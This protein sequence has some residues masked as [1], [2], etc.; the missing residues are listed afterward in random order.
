ML[1][2]KLSNR[3]SHRHRILAISGALFSLSIPAFAAESEATQAY[4][5]NG[6]LEYVGDLDE[7]ANQRLFDLY[8]KLSPKPTVLSIR[9]P[10]GEVNAGMTL[11]AWVHAHKL[12]VKVMEFCLSACANY[13]F[14]AGS[15]K[16]ISNFAVIGYHGGPR[17]PSKLQLGA[18]AQ[19]A[20]DALDA[21]GQKAF[22]DEIAEM[23]SRD[24]RRES[25][26]FREIGVSAD[27]SSLGQQAQYAQFTRANPGSAG[28]TYSL[29]GFDLLG[30]HDISVINPPWKPGSTMHHLMFVTIPVQAQATRRR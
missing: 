11:G 16:I 30:V 22:M 3:V 12:N 28:W 4:V 8:E 2:M 25:A 21:A 24:G 7:T 9:S 14:P 17:D 15:K 26:Y 27:I 23:S 1:F 10:G 5:S 29:E 13:V 6:Q 19:A 18:E 20:Y